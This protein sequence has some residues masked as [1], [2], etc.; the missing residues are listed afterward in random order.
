MLNCSLIF[1][2]LMAYIF[3]SVIDTMHFT[4][5]LCSGITY[6]NQTT[7]EE[8]KKILWLTP[9]INNF[10]YFLNN[11]ALKYT[12]YLCKHA[13]V[14][15]ILYFINVILSYGEEGYKQLI[16]FMPFCQIQMLH[17]SIHISPT[18]VHVCQQR[19]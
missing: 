8:Y 13:E 2:I 10:L 16:Y 11:N 4:Y 14:L 6:C 19:K 12:P 18:L 3:M 5:L 7:I 15:L 17:C 9:W 1:T